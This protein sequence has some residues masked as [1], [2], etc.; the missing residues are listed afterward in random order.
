MGGAPASAPKAL[1]SDEGMAA[2]N[3]DVLKTF[4]APGCDELSGVKLVAVAVIT[5]RDRKS[6]VVDKVAWKLAW[7]LPLVVTLTAPRKLCP[8]GTESGRG[9]LA[10]NSI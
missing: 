3:S 9:W 4:T 8:S 2:E 6:S 5:T 10:K 1:T 7:P